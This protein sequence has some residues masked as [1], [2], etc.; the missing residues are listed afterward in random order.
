M[1]QK[2]Q[3]RLTDATKPK[4]MD[5]FFQK[6]WLLNDRVSFVMDTTECRQISLGRILSMK[7]VLDKH[8]DNSKK[9][10]DH[11]VIIVKSG[12]TRFLLRTGLSIIKT[13]SPVYIYTSRSL[14]VGP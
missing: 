3:I 2:I 7:E 6:A 13:D 1:T 8:R 12:I 14:R 9:Y 5:T 10:I 4:D 11:T